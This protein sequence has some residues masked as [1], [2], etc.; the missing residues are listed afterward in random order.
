MTTTDNKLKDAEE[1]AKGPAQALAN[2][3][4]TR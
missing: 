2:L 3:T 4:S 1:A